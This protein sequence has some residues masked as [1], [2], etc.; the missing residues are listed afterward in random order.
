MPS[1]N[2]HQSGGSG[3]SYQ[4]VGRFCL[5]LRQPAPMRRVQS[6][7]ATARAP[8]V[9]QR[10]NREGRECRLSCRSSKIGSGHNRWGGSIRLFRIELQPI[11]NHR[12]RKDITILCNAYLAYCRFSLRGEARQNVQLI[13]SLLPMPHP[14]M[15]ASGRTCASAA[16]FRNGSVLASLA[17]RDLL[18]RAANGGIFPIRQTVREQLLRA[19]SGQTTR[20]LSGSL[21]PKRH[22]TAGFFMTIEPARSRWATRRRATISTIISWAFCARFRP[23]KRSAKASA[24]ARSEGSA[25]ARHGGMQS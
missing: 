12:R 8:V 21:K 13:G 18:G 16:G 4:G 6:H 24:D 20:R 19:H 10:D 15:S 22:C 3:V 11:R 17:F 14:A 25:G 9:G 2:S 7:C 23:W 1:S 5:S